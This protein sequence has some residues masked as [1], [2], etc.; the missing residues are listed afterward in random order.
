M[1][2]QKGVVQYMHQMVKEGDDVFLSVYNYEG[3]N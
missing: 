1:E 2:G 3:M